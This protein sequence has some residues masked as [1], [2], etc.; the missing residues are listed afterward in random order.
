MLLQEKLYKHWLQHTENYFSNAKATLL[1]RT[2]QK[3]YTA[4]SRY[5]HNLSHIDSMLQKAS[6]YKNQIKNY[7]AVVFAIWFHDIVYT[8]TSKNNEEKSAVFAKKA[9]KSNSKEMIELVYQFI[10]STKSHQIMVKE[11]LDNAFFLDFDLAILGAEWNI[12]ESYI[13]NIRKEYKM[14][15]DFLY[16]PARKKVLLNFL[17]R[18]HLFFTDTCQNLFEERARQNLEK[19]ITILT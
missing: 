5:Y 2:I 13:K 14:Y 1:W 11:N 8:A 7:D 15:P 12:Y 6:E 4:K 19:E 3:N 17:N 16:K 18:E 9:L 10:L